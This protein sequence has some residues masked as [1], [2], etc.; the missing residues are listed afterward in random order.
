MSNWLHLFNTLIEEQEFDKFMRFYNAVSKGSQQ[1]RDRQPQQFGTVFRVERPETKNTPQ[2]IWMMGL[3]LRA[4]LKGERIP[5]DIF[6]Q[7]WEQY[8]DNCLF[9]RHALTR[10]G[11]DSN[12]KANDKE[13]MAACYAV[14]M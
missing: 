1:D 14:L 11:R 13:T 4:K 6:Q 10:W 5:A 7:M 2:Q 12:I 8:I 9:H 3:L